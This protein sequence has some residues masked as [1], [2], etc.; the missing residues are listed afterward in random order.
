MK[1]HCSNFR[2]L[3]A[4]TS[5]A[6]GFRALFLFGSLLAPLLVLPF[7]SSSA[8][9]QGTYL[10]A[11]LDGDPS[12]WSGVPVAYTGGG[13]SAPDFNTLQVANDSNYLY[14]FLTFNTPLD[15]QFTSGGSSVYLAFDTDNNP[16][17]GFNVFG[18]G[19]I[20]SELGYQNDFPFQ[21]ATNNFNTGATVTNGAGLVAE[22]D[23]PSTSVYEVGIPLD[24]NINGTPLWNY[25]P[26]TTIGMAI[27][28]DDGMQ[29]GSTGGPTDF[30]GNVNYTFAAAPVP[31]PGSVALL[32]GGCLV[33]AV[34]GA[35][36][37][38]VRAC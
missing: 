1:K 10:T 4:S 26:G 22:Y 24:S 36:K 15:L 21:Q 3:I 14:F 37:F 33:M 27:Y 8:R 20:G 31:E 7:A 38:L 18:A 11:T 5:P 30:T 9:A 32:L 6:R 35:R 28:I 19:V 16:S 2:T 23:S 13:S 29:Y 17:T 34:P 25:T 12:Q